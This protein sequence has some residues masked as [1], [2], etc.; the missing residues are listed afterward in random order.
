[1]KKSKNQAH[2]L[3]KKKCLLCQSSKITTLIKRG[4]YEMIK[5]RNCDLFY[6]LPQISREK[7][8]ENYL[9]HY[10]EVD[11]SLRIAYSRKKLYKRFLR[12]IDHI[13]GKNTRLLDIGCGLGYFLFIAKN[14]G[15]KT[16]GIEM[17]PDLVKAGNQNF[18][19]NIKRGNFEESNVPTGYFDVISL[20]NVFDELYYPFRCIQKI[21]TALKPGGH[22]F[23]RI[24]NS[25]F[26]VFIYKFQ[27][28]FRKLNLKHILP[29][30]SFIFHHFNFSQKTLK[31]ILSNNGFKNIKIRNSRPTSG[32]PYEAK[33]GVVAY[34]II[35]FLIAQCI[36]ALTGYKL[37]VAPS[38]EVFA[39]NGKN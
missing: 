7:Y 16:Y 21:K 25:T 13:K 23:M 26:H 3:K 5:C 31:W 18:M 29:R 38:I 20:W 36:F 17:N 35:A 33:K 9:K 34:K 37:T 24:P 1:M 39:K 12:Q 6:R 2:F 11:P 19:L 8:F 32:D 14:D 27:K 15:W 10:S 30:H 4:D 22:F 28:I